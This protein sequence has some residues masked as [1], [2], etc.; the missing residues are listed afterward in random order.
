MADKNPPR[1]KGPHR[2]A[3]ASKLRIPNDD[4]PNLDAELDA[5]VRKVHTT[6]EDA[7]SKMSDDEVQKADK[8]AKAIFDRATSAAKSSRHSA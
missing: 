7:R 2:V 5:F 8:A 6:I 3:T 1:K 4:D